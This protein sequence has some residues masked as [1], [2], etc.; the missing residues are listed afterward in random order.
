M[1]AAWWL[2]LTFDLPGKSKK[3]ILSSGGSK[4]YHN[5]YLPALGLNEKWRRTGLSGQINITHVRRRLS[6]HCAVQ[7][8]TTSHHSAWETNLCNKYLTSRN[9]LWIIPSSFPLTPIKT[10]LLKSTAQTLTHRFLALPSVYLISAV[11]SWHFFGGKLF[12]NVNYN[13]MKQKINK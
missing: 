12:L 4:Q 3:K 2:R 10:N 11:W 13:Q 5:N 6:P 1:H 9:P 8:L 7:P